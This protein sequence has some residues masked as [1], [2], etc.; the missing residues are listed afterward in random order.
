MSKLLIIHPDLQEP[1]SSHFATAKETKGSIDIIAETLGLLLI[2]DHPVLDHKGV[3]AEYWIIADSKSLLEE[4]L[5]AFCKS[6][7]KPLKHNTKISFYFNKET[8]LK[9]IENKESKKKILLF[10][11]APKSP[12]NFEISPAAICVDVTRPTIEGSKWSELVGLVGR[13]S[14]HKDKW[15][16]L[17]C[18][19][20]T[21]DEWATKLTNRVKQEGLIVSS[22]HPTKSIAKIF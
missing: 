10:P 9:Y 16:S 17:L 15:F 21:C 8:G 20:E 5:L 3:Q 19:N 18:F 6:L 2:D 4:Y 7:N 14:S 1:I 13:Q 22:I 11:S 12:L